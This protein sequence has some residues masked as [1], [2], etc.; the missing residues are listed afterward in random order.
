MT[1]R[2]QHLVEAIK[3]AGAFLTDAINGLHRRFYE[4]ADKDIRSAKLILDDA[5]KDAPKP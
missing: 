2:E 4:E 1:D 5:A 3:E